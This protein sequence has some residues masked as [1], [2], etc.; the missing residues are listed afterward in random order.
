MEIKRGQTF[1]LFPITP[2][3]QKHNMS[4]KISLQ[5]FYIGCVR[6]TIVYLSIE[7]TD[8]YQTGSTCFFLFQNWHFYFNVSFSGHFL[9]FFYSNCAS[10]QET[11]KKKHQKK[12]KKNDKK[13]LIHPES[14]SSKLEIFLLQFIDNICGHYHHEKNI[15]FF[16]IFFLSTLFEFDRARKRE[17]RN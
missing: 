4:Q 6:G 11:Q 5:R 17:I 13:F 14:L 10:C 2:D 1:A 7:V 15:L 12:K 8:W 3:L 9:I 16:R